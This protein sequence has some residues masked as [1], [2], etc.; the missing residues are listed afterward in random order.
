MMN[1][2]IQNI[3]RENIGRIEENISLKKYTT[4]KVGG[5]ARCV[6][7]P[8]N[9]DKLVRLIKLLN[10]N[11]IKYKIIGNGSNLLFSDKDYDGILI[12]LV[13]FDDIE[14]NDNRIKVGAGYSLMKLSRIAMKNSLTGLE[15]AAGIP[16]TVGGAVF[17]NAGAYK[18]DM[19]YIV[20]SVKVL[21]PDYRII[22]LENREL[23]FHYRT[24]YLKKHPKY[25]C[26]EAVI[27]LEHGSRSAIE[28]LMKERLKRR[29]SSQPL[30]YPSAG[31]VFRNPK[32]MFAGELIENLGLKGMK[33]NGAMI[34]DKHANF[35]VN[36]GNA[37]SEDI[38]YLI[39]Y[40]YNKVK[41]KYNV[42]MVVEQEFVN[43]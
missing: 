17:M 6:V 16:G 28:N 11:N 29:M 4:Y 1:E 20:K 37:K 21:T 22:E 15:F 27:K 30:N 10:Q 13:D 34:S 12:K 36:T 31:S 23:D 9:V 32:D 19:G 38:K 5:K 2:V 40:A 7:Y 39:D 35:I 14:I 3:K 25:I 8:K 43:W 41:E 24:S 33:H 26:L 18:S 42:E